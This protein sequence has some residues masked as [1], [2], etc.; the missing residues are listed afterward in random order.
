MRARFIN[1]DNKGIYPTSAE[2]EKIFNQLG[3]L[4]KI[5]SMVKNGDSI[6]DIIEYY[7]KNN[8]IISK[9]NY[10]G[11]YYFYE[12]LKE[13]GINPHTLS[14]QPAQIKKRQDKI[15]S[16]TL[17]NYGVDNIGKS[18]EHKEK[19]SK[20]NKD[21][22]KY[23]NPFSSL[24]FKYLEYIKGKRIHPDDL[25]DFIEFRQKTLEETNKNKKDVL[26]NG[27]C[28]YT[29]I[30]IYKDNNINNWDKASLDHKISILKA[31]DQ[32]MTPE[33][34]GAVDNLCWCSKYFNSI[35]KEYTEKEIEYLGFV[36]KFKRIYNEINKERNS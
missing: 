19:M 11:R 23:A 27:K 35:K 36:T 13:M 5:Q 25:S 3:G 9:R 24:D 10:F 22:A 31:F 16:T 21:Q 8:P 29:E 26:F 6:S 2:I 30:P 34:T 1:E 32:G 7:N 12:K 4:D 28:Y 14:K 20:L 17:K 18:T 33:E 15:R